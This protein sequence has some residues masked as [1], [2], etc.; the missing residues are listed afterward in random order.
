MKIETNL[1]V[2]NPKRL[3]GKYIGVKEMAVNGPIES[4]FQGTSVEDSDFLPLRCP[5]SQIRRCSA[6]HWFSLSLSH[7]HDLRLHCEFIRPEAQ[8]RSLIRRRF[9]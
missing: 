1:K 3:K 6:H 8:T 2:E 4:V 7:T 9:T 5:P